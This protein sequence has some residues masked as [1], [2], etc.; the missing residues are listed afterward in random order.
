MPLGRMKISS[1]LG[2]GHVENAHNFVGDWRGSLVCDDFSGYKV[3]LANGVA[4]V[5]CMTHARRKF[6]ELHVANKSQ[7]AQYSLELMGQL[8]EQQGKVLDSDA[9][10]ELRQERSRPIADIL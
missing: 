9:R 1:F 10:G 3:M 5:G 8:Y 7:I 4:K 6:F 2:Q